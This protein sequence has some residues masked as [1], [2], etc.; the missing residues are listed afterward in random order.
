[1]SSINHKLGIRPAGKRAMMKLPRDRATAAELT[2]AK[3]PKCQRRGCFQHVINHRLLRM[4]P[5]CLASW[6]PETA[7]AD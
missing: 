7:H 6:S 1:M 2:S 3:C 5:W 4:C